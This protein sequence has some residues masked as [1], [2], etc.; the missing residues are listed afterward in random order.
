MKNSFVSLFTLRNVWRFFLIGIANPWVYVS[1]IITAFAMKADYYVLAI[2][3]VG[4]NALF[5]AGVI[6]F[7]TPKK[8]THA[9]HIPTADLFNALYDATAFTRDLVFRYSLA[10]WLAFPC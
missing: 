5:C 2:V 7:A 3:G 6:V 9:K 1:A 8:K 10:S 4:I